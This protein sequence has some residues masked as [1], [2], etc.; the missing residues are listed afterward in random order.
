MDFR[1]GVERGCGETGGD[2]RREEYGGGGNKGGG[3][4]ERAEVGVWG[5]GGMWTNSLIYRGIGR[6]GGKK[7]NSKTGWRGHKNSFEN[8]RGWA[9]GIGDGKGELNI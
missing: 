6:E 3:G 9:D 4:K 7:D 8:Y 5:G 2:L 1:R